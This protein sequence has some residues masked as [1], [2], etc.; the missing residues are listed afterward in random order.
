[1]DNSTYVS[2]SQAL[3]LERSLDVTANNI[4]NSNTAGFR[5]SRV[6]FNS[7]V[8]QTS[9]GAGTV[10]DPVSYVRPSTGHI[11]TRPGPL[12]RTGNPLDVAL[13]G[14][15][16]F[17][18]RTAAGQT[19][20]GRDGRLAV[21]A[22]GN[23]VT[24]NGSEILDD[25]GSP[26]AIP[27]NSA[28]GLQI[29]TDGTITDRTGATLARIGVVDVPDIANFQRSD[30]GMF[31]PPGGTTPATT[32]ATGTK[33]AQGFLEQSNVEPVL[34]LTRMMEIQR[35]YDR[36]MTLLSDQNDLRKQTLSQLGRLG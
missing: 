19:A 21:N 22:Q 1:M 14:T 9:D 4:A 27:A 3:A 25:A 6:D 28:G 7:L 29:G 17:S 18:Y 34:E 35:A 30:G 20:Y 16:W 8:E 31:I 32:P 26:I 24:V 33:I 10:P 12:Q 11:D 5:A 23:L 2:I 15:G 13:S 36:A